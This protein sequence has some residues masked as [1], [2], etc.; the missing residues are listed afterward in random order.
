MLMNIQEILIL[1][2]KHGLF[3]KDEIPPSIYAG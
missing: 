2:D 3:E 1:E